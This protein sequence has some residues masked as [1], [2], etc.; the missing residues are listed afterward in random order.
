[1]TNE[2]IYLGIDEW[3]ALL[4]IDDSYKAPDA[5]L[6]ILRNRERREDL[7][8]EALAR[9]NYD[10]GYDWFHRYFQDE[11]ADRAQKKQDCSARLHML[12]V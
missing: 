10:V 4:G 2:Q 3:N 5:L 7:F 8:R 9:H 1:M 12:K 11:H 6:E